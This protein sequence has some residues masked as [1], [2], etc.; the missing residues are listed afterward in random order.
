MRQRVRRAERLR[1]LESSC[2]VRPGASAERDEP[3]E[4]MRVAFPAVCER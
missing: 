3:D 4:E 1:A 2:C